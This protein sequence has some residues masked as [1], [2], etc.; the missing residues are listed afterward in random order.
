MLSSMNKITREGILFCLCGPAG[1]G[2]TTVARHLVENNPPCA[3]SV[4][5]TSRLPRTGEV[6]GKDYHFVN[7]SEFE[8]R[9]AADELFEYE[10]V[11]GNLY[12]TLKSSVMESLSGGVDLLL[13]IDIKGA[14]TFKNQLPNNTV[15]V[16]LIPPSASVLKER[17]IARGKMTEEELRKRL[18][19]AE[20]EYLSLVD[21]KNKQII[22]YVVINNILDETCR[23]VA[24]ILTGERNRLSRT[25]LD[26]LKKVCVV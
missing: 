19:T 4:S 7:R 5:V 17:L 1:A 22:D 3:F 20:K 23:I 16:F 8:R 11:H 26:S 14:L 2:K 24:S 9:I 25:N 10:E 6:D 12:G 15:I 21:S 13:D 18:N